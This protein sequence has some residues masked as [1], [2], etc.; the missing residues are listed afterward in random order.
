MSNSPEKSCDREATFADAKSK[1]PQAADEFLTALAGSGQ[2]VETVP[3]VR[4]TAYKGNARTH[5]KKQIR[6]IADSITRFGFCNPV[7][8]DDANQ[9]IAGHGRVEAA[10]S[11]GLEGV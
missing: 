11:L 8:I 10:K 3:I 7:L 2:Q 4:L 5:T 6:Q 9:I 1:H